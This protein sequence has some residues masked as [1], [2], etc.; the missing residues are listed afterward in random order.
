MTDKRSKKPEP[1]VLKPG[2]RVDAALRMLRVH[3]KLGGR[4]LQDIYPTR[5]MPHVGRQVMQEGG[6]V[7]PI[8]DP[9]GNVVAPGG[10]AN[11]PPPHPREELEKTV[12]PEVAEKLSVAGLMIPNRAAELRETET[13]LMPYDREGKQIPWMT[14]PGILPLTRDEGEVRWAM[15]YALEMA[16]N[17]LGSVV[18]PVRGAGTVLGS[19]PIRRAA[20]EAA[21][22]TPQVLEAAS[23]AAR[24]LT[25]LGFYSHAAEVAAQ[26]KQ[27]GNATDIMNWLS[28]QPGVKREE[29]VAAGLLDEVGQPTQKLVEMGKVTPQQLSEAIRTGAPNVEEV[30]YGSRGVGVSGEKPKF[31]PDVYPD[32]TTPDT[33]NYREIILRLPETPH[34]PTMHWAI[35]GDLFHNERFATKEDAFAAIQG[36]RNKLANYPEDDPIRQLFE[37]KLNRVQLRE[38]IDRRASRDPN[39]RN[40]GHFEDVPNP[41]VHMRVTEAQVP[42][43]NGRAL[44]IEEIQSDW[45]QKGRE[46]GFYSP[47]QVQDAVQKV[48]ALEE[49]SKVV[50]DAYRNALDKYGLTNPSFSEI[51]GND[52]LT[53]LWSSKNSISTQLFDARNEARKAEKSLPNAPYIQDTKQ[54]TDL[55]VKRAF[56]EAID[57]DVSELQITKGDVHRKRYQGYDE[58]DPGYHY[59]VNIPSSL[60]RVLKQI[61]PDAKIT[62]RSVP[63]SEAGASSAVLEVNEE[64]SYIE[65]YIKD[66][67]RALDRTTDTERGI[68][69]SEAIAEREK[70]IES[71]Q[72]K[73]QYLT[74][75][76]EFW[77]VEITPK[78]REAVQ[79]GLTR[80]AEG[81]PVTDE[82][83][84]VDLEP[85]SD[86]MGNI[87]APGGL[88]NPPPPHPREKLEAEMDPVVAEKLAIAGVMV[89]NR[90]AELRE[91]DIG[92]MPY[93][94]EGNPMPWVKRPGFWP[95]VSD[96]GEGRWA[97]PYGLEVAGNLLGSVVSPAGPG[98]TVLGSG[99]TRRGFLKG[100]GAS[101]AAAAAPESLITAAKPTATAMDVS[102]ATPILEEILSR[103]VP[104]DNP[105]VAKYADPRRLE[106]EM[107]YRPFREDGGQSLST[108]ELVSPDRSDTLYN[109][110]ATSNQRGAEGAREVV[111]EVSKPFLD[112]TRKELETKLGHPVTDEEFNGLVDN[113]TR[114]QEA[115][116]GLRQNAYEASV[117]GI[118]MDSLN[119]IVMD[120]ARIAGEVSKEA[121]PRAF[122]D[123]WNGIFER[124][125]PEVILEKQYGIP[126]QD[127][128][129]VLD[130][131]F[132]IEQG[133]SN[134]STMTIREYL[135]YVSETAHDEW[136]NAANAAD[137]RALKQSWNEGVEGPRG[138]RSNVSDTTPSKSE[139][140]MYESGVKNLNFFRNGT[141][142]MEQR[143]AQFQEL[144]NN[145]SL[146]G[147]RK[148]GIPSWL[149]GNYLEWIKEEF[150]KS[151]KLVQNATKWAEKEQKLLEKLQSKY[152]NYDFT[153]IGGEARPTA[154]TKPATQAKPTV[155]YDYQRN[156]IS[157]PSEVKQL[158]AQSTLQDFVKGSKL[159]DEQG[160]PIRLYHGT[161]D[162]IESFD[163]NHPNRKDSG[164][165][166]TG[167]YMTDS[168]ALASSYSTLKSPGRGE[169]V[170]PLYAR[171]ENPYYATQAEKD[172]IKN[173]EMTQGKEA[174][175]EASDAFTKWLR[176]QGYDG[177]ILE[178]FPGTAAA[179]REVVVF[180]PSHVKSATGNRGTFDVKEPDLTKA[181]G[182][183]VNTLPDDIFSDWQNYRA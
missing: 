66:L 104:L 111:G 127:V 61:D 22:H 139:L 150:D 39:L 27:A 18:E 3:K 115:I 56:K 131:P 88:A 64:I 54:W 9:M 59:D 119:D 43:S 62:T 136:L 2:A 68:M 141:I 44:R 148:L 46:R 108:W 159:V 95:R 166:G 72:K 169:N 175:R 40:F 183:A 75:P 71:L 165:L 24:E 138:S 116:S 52:E 143:L 123:V 144:A 160:Q 167:V 38:V 98:G 92:L 133:V 157:Q 158:P 97:M 31:G 23:Q 57:A 163:L 85:I 109:A 55:A 69:I 45:S 70:E 25:P 7:E 100:M 110:I 106:Y 47:Q 146:E 180:E 14:R 78:I 124:V 140:E 35:S 65:S 15:P 42:G 83:K 76:N 77:V 168:P 182:G 142:E 94:A 16:G 154:D 17:V 11:P 178:S 101:A 172:I 67:A 96:E 79:R 112:K 118:D 82:D 1:P 155:E 102:K 161:A 134:P 152:P 120:Y 130:Q 179:S 49:Q 105:L 53:K 147:A 137:K 84:P 58:G 21:T 117:G 29:L 128:A 28:K 174:A 6:D 80:F 74:A 30:V 177:V 126:K 60:K 122:D 114:R 63:V 181:D 26:A 8:Y 153:S 151:P 87:A 156:V 50:G 86:P 32:L 13:G 90:A 48:R 20:T 5:Y 10:L 170:M 89:P 12:S 93:D 145:P 41:I 36:M 51:S 164:W 81:G 121:P 37:D 4:L 162:N 125:T 34:T 73:L 33:E 99:I 19:G 103:P 176:E 129:R 91:T 173:I 149:E 135:D 132:P 171:L 107:D 113:L